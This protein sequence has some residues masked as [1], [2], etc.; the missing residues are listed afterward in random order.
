M[1]KTKVE[2]LICG[3]GISKLESHMGYH[4]IKKELWNQYIVTLSPVSKVHSCDQCDYK[5]PSK[6]NLNKHITRHSTKESLFFCH[7]CPKEFRS[8]SGL[9]SH[10]KSEHSNFRY[11]CTEKNCSTTF[12]QIKSFR[13]HMISQHEGLF[14]S[15]LVREAYKCNSCD[16][17]FSYTKQDHLCTDTQKHIFRVVQGYQQYIANADEMKK[18]LIEFKVEEGKELLATVH[19]PENTNEEAHN[20]TL[21][22]SMDDNNQNSRNDKVANIPTE[23]PDDYEKSVHVEDIFL[24]EKEFYI[25]SM[26]NNRKSIHR[27]FDGL[28]ESLP[29][30]KTTKE[31]SDQIINHHPLN[32]QIDIVIKIEQQDDVECL[33]EKNATRSKSGVRIVKVQPLNHSQMQNNMPDINVS[34]PS[35]KLSF[36]LSIVNKMLDNVPYSTQ[37]SV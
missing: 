18:R 36:A 32:E 8:L 11:Q 24:N 31:V 28:M 7:S 13:N 3:K 37:L 9:K 16:K 21:P 27:D 2:C 20:L 34:P 5:T 6:S 25:P 23:K 33:I 15:D 29:K 35:D 30:T 1:P 4:N 10:K 12:V 26:I 17:Y 14:T 19:I 22:E